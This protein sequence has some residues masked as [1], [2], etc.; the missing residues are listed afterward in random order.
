[1]EHDYAVLMSKKILDD[2]IYYFYPEILIEGTLFTEDD[3]VYF[4]D[5]NENTYLT[6]HDSDFVFSDMQNGV[7]YVISEEDLLNKYPNLSIHE[8]KVEYFD[9]ICRVSHF[10][11]YI[12]NEDIIGIVPM[13]LKELSE[14]INSQNL[15]SDENVINLNLMDISQP[16]CDSYGRILSE[17][18]QAVSNEQIDTVI[19]D[20]EV[21]KLLLNAKNFEEVRNILNKIIA[22][23]KEYNPQV[24][25]D[26]ISNNYL[27]KK[28]DD[29]YEAFTNIK[30][31]DEMKRCIKELIDFYIELS[32]SLDSLN[33]KNTKKANEFL[34]ALVDTYDALLKSNDL[35]YIKATIKRIGQKSRQNIEKLSSNY[36]L[37]QSEVKPELKENNATENNKE[38][39]N[40]INA[41]D[42]KN[43]MDQ[44][45]IGQEE[46]K[47][48]VISAIIMN[49]LGEASDKNSCLLVGPTG[50][51]KTL[52]AETISEYLDLPMEIVDTTQLTIPGYVGANIEDFLLRLLI[53]AGGVVAKAEEGIIVFDEIDKKGSKENDDVSGKG[54]LNTLLP[55]LQGTTYNVNYNGK[56]IPFNTSKLTIFATG[57]FTD[58]A[59]AKKKNS[60]GNLYKETHIGYNINSPK[61]S[62]EDIVYE[63]LETED[64]VKY[65]HMPI[66]LIGRFS[67]IT[68]LHGHTEESLKKILNTSLYSPIL[69]EQTKLMK[70]N[71]SLSWDDAYIDAV[72]KK[73]LQLKTGAR[74]LKNIVEYSIKVARW[75][76]LVNL[77]KYR[78]IRLNSNTPFDNTDVY[79]IDKEGNEILLKEISV[80]NNESLKLAKKL[81]Q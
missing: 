15:A 69:M 27:L 18:E 39:K 36:E 45:I 17:S 81:K 33:N 31:L 50:S 25:E 77:D 21:F 65:G 44:R 47:K 51:G 38:I 1:M 52:I 5:I 57:A 29:S 75:E 53:K 68:Q 73:A 40:K 6:I 60:N 20:M 42:I 3:D 28:F 32:V 7:G 74:S 48:D 9:S 10:G 71:I 41:K 4:K 67:T 80:D 34:Y 55:F 19:L 54:V 61:E 12:L 79:I 66:E 62:K 72:V 8:A 23:I 78:E 2:G 70:L 22:S 16:N 37:F 35:E 26:N 13:N 56:I 64:F 49:K 58:V 24:L 59:L 30:S 11:F 76:A 46:A 14:K 43:Y 63:K